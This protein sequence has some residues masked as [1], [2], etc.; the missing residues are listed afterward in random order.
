MQ[1]IHLDNDKV[2]LYAINTSNYDEDCIKA[3]LTNLFNF[4][5]GQEILEP[6]Y[7]K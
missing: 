7:R 3:S 4:R 2:I 6:E 5:L 1:L